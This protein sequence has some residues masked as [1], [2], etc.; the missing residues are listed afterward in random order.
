ML[1]LG[2]NA[3]AAPGEDMRHCPTAACLTNA[4]SC[5]IDPTHDCS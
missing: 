1:V 4:P 5:L 3:A 2:V